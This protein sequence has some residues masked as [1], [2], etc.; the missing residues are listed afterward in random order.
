MSFQSESIS[1]IAIIKE[2]ITRLANY[3][4]ISIEEHIT[5]NKDTIPSFLSL[6]QGKLDHELNLERKI[7][8]LEALQELST[9]E[10]DDSWLSNDYRDILANQEQIRG[11]Y[12]KR[13]KSLEFLTGI[14][15]D[16]FVD[17]NKIQG[18]DRR[19]MIPKLQKTIMSGNFKEL[20]AEFFPKNNK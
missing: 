20:V 16:L 3:H 8:L 6:I 15:T 7:N 9:S 5:E 4:R 17:W 2:N 10:T 19:K 13:G 14:I 12:L 11:Q 18:I 1:T